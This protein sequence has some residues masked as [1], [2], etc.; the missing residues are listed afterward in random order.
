MKTIQPYFFW[1]FFLMTYTALGQSLKK[2][3][4]TTK[5]YDQWHDMFKINLSEDGKWAAYTFEYKSKRDTTFVKEIKSKRMYSFPKSSDRRLNNNWFSCMQDTSL[6]LLNLN[7]K[8]TASIPSVSQYTFAK[9]DWLVLHLNENKEA[10]LLVKDNL[11]KEQYRFENTQQFFLNP[12]GTTL[13]LMQKVNATT[14]LSL[15]P[16]SSG[17]PKLIST[18]SGASLSNVTWNERGDSVAFL[19]SGTGNHTLY[20]YRTVD[21]QLLQ[22][23]QEGNWYDEII[24]GMTQ[25]CI[26]PSGRLLFWTH[27]KQIKQVDPNI[28]I[29]NAQDDFLQI[30][31]KKFPHFQR[32]LCIWQ[33]DTGKVEVFE[34]KAIYDVAAHGRFALCRNYKPYLPSLKLDPQADYYLLDLR[35]G[36]E[37]LLLTDYGM[38]RSVTLLPDGKSLLYFKEANWWR[39]TIETAKHENLTHQLPVSF[40]KDEFE[41]RD[42]DYPIAAPIVADNG[43]AILIYDTNDIWKLDQAGKNP[44]RLT[45]GKEKRQVFRIADIDLYDKEKP[46]WI[47]NTGKTYKANQSLLLTCMAEDYTQYGFGWLDHKKEFKVQHMEEKR[48]EIIAKNNKNLFLRTQSF[49][50]PPALLYWEHKKERALPIVQSNLQHKKYAW[51]ST[52]SIHYTN[53]KDEPLQGVLFYPANY[54]AQKSYPMVVSIYQKRG[55]ERHNY[56]NPSYYNPIGFNVSNL[57]SK[58]YFVLL[59][60][61]IYEINNPGYSA[62]DCVMAA[63]KSALE[64]KAIDQTNVALIGHSFGGYETNFIVTQTSFFKTA[65]ASAGVT[66]FTSRYFSMS[67]NHTA[68]ETWRFEF[69]QSR[70]KGPLFNYRTQYR[71]NS[72][73]E[74]VENVTTPLLTWTGEKDT[75]VN[76]YQSMEFYIALRRLGKP[77]IMLT[78]PE[79]GHVILNLEKQ[80]DLT[81]KM[82]EWL[83][84][85]LKKGEQPA[86]MIPNYQYQTL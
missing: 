42:P 86:W 46:F 20:L 59:P 75:Q 81:L 85:Y 56:K 63:V 52:K 1:L 24:T 6:Q 25:M 73:I 74:Y 9:N 60:D 72:P 32:T 47:I 31:N 8:K 18:V 36:E 17:V 5:D 11:G 69:A 40:V 33:P 38:S 76:P 45:K 29:W 53:D 22:V 80:K 71:R 49:G 55:Y 51:G 57:T 35:S 15:I 68:P 13:L 21:Q 3:P 41:K 27:K 84:Y 66:D 67:E 39:Y 16:L 26:D 64:L 58:G 82:E 65:I 70:M 77:H 10:V 2:E 19:D 83:D 30:R 50:S 48:I 34:N 54:D 14:S 12:S 78:Y 7:T 62:L 28:N 61:I 44:I 43:S 23:Q 4:V 37:R 79:E